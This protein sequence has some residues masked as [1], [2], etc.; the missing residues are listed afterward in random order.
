MLGLRS[1]GLK[2]DLLFPSVCGEIQ[3]RGPYI[4]VKTPSNPSFIWGNFLVYRRPPGAGDLSRWS[5]AFRDAF[6]GDPE[7]RHQAFTWDEPGLPRPVPAEFA[8]AGFEVEPSSILTAARLRPGPHP[9][10]ELTIRPLVSEGDW[11]SATRNQIRCR[12]RGWEA[13]SYGRFKLR[14]MRAY[15]TV[16]EA[17]HGRW[18]GAF[19][20]DRL[21]GDLGIFQVA[22]LGRYQ[23]V[24]TDPDYRRRGVCSALILEAGRHALEKLGAKTLVIMSGPG[25]PAERVYRSLGLRPTQSLV[26]VFRRSAPTHGT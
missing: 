19:I 13:A 3:D 14:Q 6:E 23:S 1:L 7:V 20:N 18:F 22:G 21:V 17:G 26:G 9:N 15:R 10:N 24:G 11:E 4:V 25:S 16:A 8:A 5:A 2:T 12:A